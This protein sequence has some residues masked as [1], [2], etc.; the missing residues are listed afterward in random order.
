M[1]ATLT[2]EQKA[3]AER[4]A[5]NELVKKLNAALE[6]NGQLRDGLKTVTE[7][8]NR[9]K[10]LDERFKDLD[11]K[12]VG[13]QYNEI[14]SGLEHIQNTMRLSKGGIYV[15]GLGEEKQK[16]SIAR[17]AVA[18][19]SKSWGQASFEERV[20]KEAREAMTKGV[21]HIVGVDSQGGF[22]VPDQVIPE[23]IAAIYHQSIMISLDGTGT[24]RV[25]VLNGLTGIPVTIPKFIGGMIAYWIG[26]QDKFVESAVRVGNVSMRPRKLGV[27]T[28]ITDEMRR[29]S[30]YGFETLMRADMV[31][32][33]AALIDWT[34]FF[35]TGT[36]NMPRGIIA[37][38]GVKRYWAETHSDVAP[39]G[40]AAGGVLTYDDLDNMKGVVEDQNIPVQPSWSWISNPR[41]FRRLRQAKV[42]YFS[43]QTTNQ[44]YLLGGPMLDDARLSSVIG[45]WASS[46]AIPSNNAAGQDFGDTPADGTDKKYGM[47]AG[48]NWNDVLFGRWGGLELMEDQGLGKGFSTDET[49]I[50]ARMYGDLGYR[51]PQT[52]VIADDVK[53]RDA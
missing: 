25:S 21:G 1:A 26:E 6:E 17:A 27:L 31:R 53:M 32:A 20:F 4:D 42:S 12:K 24:T 22:F 11:P 37:Q 16:F 33:A 30:S 48:G 43:G 18:I 38:E 5:A 13:E 3:A 51:A 15:P 40:N 34:V 47:V 44:G 28:R 7:E 10:A 45:P 41:F 2:P 8:V 23:V 35:G 19:A 29:F 49:F 46:T 50:K 52:I 36:D 39:A 14:K 9:L